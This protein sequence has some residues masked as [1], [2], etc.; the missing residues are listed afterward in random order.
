M[1]ADEKAEM[2][3]EYQ[4]F[5][6]NKLLIQ[7]Y[8]GNFCL[9]EYSAY[10]N[11]MLK[12]EEWLSVEK[13]LT[14]IRDIDLEVALEFLNEM[15]K[16]RRKVIQKKYLNVFLVDSIN[17]TVFAHLYQKIQSKKY[18]YFHCSTIEYAMQ[19]LNINKT[20]EEV[21][22]IISNLKYSFPKSLK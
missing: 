9:E 17:N 1:Y 6:E 12:K 14:D 7:K 5:L 11:Y 16:I 8:Y 2:K 15:S 10:V 21:E 22:H 19:L 18:N 4:F 20:A 13:I 3:I